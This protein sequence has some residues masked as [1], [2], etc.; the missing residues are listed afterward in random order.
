VAAGPKLLVTGF[1]PFPNAPENP[2]QAL[3]LGL[4]AEPAESYG[5]T[6][7]RAVVLPT[8][9][10][11]SWPILRRLYRSFAPDVVVHFGLSRQASGLVIER[12]GR[13]RI[14][15]SRLDA[16]GFAPP[17]GLCRRSGPESLE[18]TLPVT[19]IAGALTEEEYPAAISEDAGGYVCNA[20]LYRSLLVA[21]AGKRLVGFVHVPPEGA[22]G[23][24]RAR[25][26]SAATLMLRG[27]AGA[28][29]AAKAMSYGEVRLV[30]AL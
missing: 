20:T 7:F 2:T 30:N 5:A 27:A 22:G 25:L 24:T 15:P 14:D 23:Y 12:C 26:S 13:K 19:R 8:D 6:A 28:W 21:P 1:G 29:T 16:V 9:Y 17:S 10:R 3:V 11:K 4:A 18:A